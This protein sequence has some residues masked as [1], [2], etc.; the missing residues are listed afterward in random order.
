VLLLRLR[1]WLTARHGPS[2]ASVRRRFVALDL[3]TTGLNPRR[4]A[5]VSLAMIPFVDGVPRAGYVTLVDPGRP[6]PPESTA[7]HGLTDGMV[8]GAPPIDRV[9]REVEAVLAADVVVGYNVGF[10]LAILG[11]ERRA[12]RLHRS[13]NPGL[14]TRLLAAGLHPEWRDVTLEHIAARLG[15][16]VVARHTAEGD[17][18]TAGH[19]LLGLLPELEAHGLRTVSE[20]LWLQRRALRR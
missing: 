20:L 2:L 13:G 11:R 9:L 5:V 10:D 7:V 6:I 8:R 19:I 4:D 16:A 14:D 18:L 1:A 17:A 12:H 3:E 15:V